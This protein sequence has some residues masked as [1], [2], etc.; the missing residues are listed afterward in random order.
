ML[1]TQ[2]R[3]AAELPTHEAPVICL[4]A[5]EAA[6]AREC[7]ANPVSAVG[8]DNLAYIIFTS[9]TTAGPRGC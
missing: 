5:D 9:G 2:E 8:A 6:I 7:T 1:L 3:F 4:D